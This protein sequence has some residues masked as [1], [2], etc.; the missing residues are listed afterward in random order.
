MEHFQHRSVVRQYL[1]DQLIEP[2]IARQNREMTHQDA[3][4]ALPLIGV[5]YHEGD[6]GLARPHHDVA[7][8]AG[9]RRAAVFIDFRDQCDMVFEIDV[10]EERDLLLRKVLFGSKKSALDLL[11]TRTFDRS[12]HLLFVASAKRADFNQAAIT[13]MF[14]NRIVRESKHERCPLAGVSHRLCR[15][16]RGISPSNDA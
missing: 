14:H 5:D 16:V 7:S 4:D 2:A 8:G 9:N 11:R 10:E 15:L 1:R 3:A 6:L 13:Q 12:Q